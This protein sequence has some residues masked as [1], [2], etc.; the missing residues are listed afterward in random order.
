M[1]KYKL[2]ID[3]G[4][5]FIESFDNEELVFNRLLELEELNNNEDLPYIDIKVF[6]GKKDITEDIFKTYNFKKERIGF[7]K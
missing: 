6:K 1:M 3:Y 4:K 7:L 2:I 5:P